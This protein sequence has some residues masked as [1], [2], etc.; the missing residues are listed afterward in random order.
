MLIKRGN[1]I[2]MRE[3]VKILLR[4]DKIWL[5]ICCSVSKEDIEVLSLGDWV[6][7]GILGRNKENMKLR[8][9]EMKVILYYIGVI[10][11]LEVFK[12]KDWKFRFGE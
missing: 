3:C 8:K 10:G 12:S 5:V 2:N 9:F 1:G 11:Y 6:D 7:V 4:E